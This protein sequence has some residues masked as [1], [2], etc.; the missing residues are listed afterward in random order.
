VRLGL[1]RT[2]APVLLF[3]PSAP[4]EGEYQRA[5]LEA[6]GELELW[7]G[8]P[9]LVLDPDR[10]DQ[11]LDAG[12]VVLD[13]GGRLRRW[14][15]VEA[16]RWGLFIADRWGVLYFATRQRHARGL[17]DARELREWVKFLATQCPECGVID[18]PP[19]DDRRLQED[20]E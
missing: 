1:P 5:F 20:P 7:D 10:A 6:A 16:D 18:Q 14:L 8:R 13:A 15:G 12:R 3:P 4:S 19:P 2:G 9:L 11:P 17:P